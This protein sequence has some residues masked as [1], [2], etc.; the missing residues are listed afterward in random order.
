MSGNC[1]PTY[2]FYN[3]CDCNAAPGGTGTGGNN[4]TSKFIWAPDSTS[5]YLPDFVVTTT[6]DPLGMGGK[7]ASVDADKKDFLNLQA[8]QVAVDLLSLSIL[9]F[10]TPVPSFND[11][12]PSYTASVDFEIVV[13]NYLG[14]TLRTIS[15]AP[16]NYKTL[17]DR[18]WTPIPLTAVTA[19]L[20]IQVGE[21]VAARVQFGAA[22]PNIRLYFTLSGIGQ[23]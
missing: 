12:P 13:L 20:S 2:N 3:C 21:V 16:M 19:D 14:I 8:L 6:P 11:I 18:K 1:A 4:K 7:V 9:R 10:A 15:Q 5:T 22:D 17:L 23:F